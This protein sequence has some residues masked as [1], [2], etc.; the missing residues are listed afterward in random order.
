MMNQPPIDELTYKTG[1]NKYI[2]SIVASKR[3]KEIEATRRQELATADK[4]AISL[5]LEEIYKDEVTFKG[6]AEDED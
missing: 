5:A 3:A 6:V 2:L 1:K 4:K